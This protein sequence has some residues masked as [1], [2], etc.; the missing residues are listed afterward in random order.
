MIR[1]ESTM[2]HR[3]IQYYRHIPAPEETVAYTDHRR[4]VP[5]GDG[6]CSTAS[7]RVYELGGQV[8]TSPHNRGM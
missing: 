8:C 2:D 5:P 4:R 7:C 3:M 1:I 6:S